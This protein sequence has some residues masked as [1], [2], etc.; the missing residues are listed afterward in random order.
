MVFTKENQLVIIFIIFV[1]IIGSG[2]VLVKHFRPGLFMGEPDY[3]A[4]NDTVEHEDKATKTTDS[5]D[6]QAVKSETP[7]SSG[8]ENEL[9]DLNRATVEQ[10]QQLP[11]IG[12]VKAKRIVEYRK[13][14]RRF[15]S[16]EQL[17]EV[18]GIGEKTFEKLKDKVIVY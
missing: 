12:P 1:V 16:V 17:M 13:R 5:E 11:R 8:S 10:L 7:S 4:G 14:H 15:I 2:V 3:V 18:R 9:I 6:L